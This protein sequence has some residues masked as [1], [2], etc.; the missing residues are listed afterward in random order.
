M[1]A[2]LSRRLARVAH[3]PPIVHLTLSERHTLALACRRADEFSNLSEQH[4]QLILEAEAAR[5][6]AIT[7]RQAAVG[8]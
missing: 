7:G 4:R 6:R 1:S 2:E 3:Q 8:Q 5:D